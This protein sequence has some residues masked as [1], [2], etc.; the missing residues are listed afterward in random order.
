MEKDK[1]KNSE[2]NPRRYWM[3]FAPLLIILAVM[4]RFPV[5][6]ML[7]EVLLDVLIYGGLAVVCLTLALRIWR[8]SKWQFWRLMV[9]MLLCA[10]FSAWQAIDVAILH[11]D[12]S[13]PCFGA[14][15]CAGSVSG[16][17][18]PYEGFGYSAARFPNPDIEC[19]HFMYEKFW[20]NETIAI[21]VRIRHAGWWACG[22]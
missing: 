12:S 10:A 19:G 18:A 22:G 17:I 11:K 13:G 9:V 3:V 1:R 15:A 6:F 21:R 2:I 16:E 8:L 7:E 14:E 5:W 4:L 20:G